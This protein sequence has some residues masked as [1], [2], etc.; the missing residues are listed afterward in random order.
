MK[1]FAITTSLILTAL[2]S[3]ELAYATAVVWPPAPAPARVEYVRQ[4]PLADLKPQTSFL[5]SIGRF[6][7][8]GTDD[9]ILG[10]PFNL[11]VTADR[12]YLTC[13]DHP[14]LVVIDPAENK[15]LRRD[16]EDHPMVSPIGLAQ[17]GADIYVADSGN[18][19]VYRWNGDDLEPWV[20]TGLVRPTGLIA[21]PKEQRIVVID[22]GD[23]QLKVFDSAGILLETVSQRGEHIGELNFPTF[24]ARLGDDLLVND[25]LNYQI[26]RFD[27]TGTLLTTFGAEGD[28]PGTFARPKGLAVDADANIWVVDALF[29]NI[30]VFNEQGQLLLVIGG[31]GQA[32]GE[33]WSPVGISVYRD[34]IYIADTFNHRIQVLRYLGGEF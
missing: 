6:L 9:E 33:F 17:L 22:T 34:E 8:G 27:S 7:G 14:A 32:E 4:I 13:Q 15:Y 31:P 5:G 2:L 19:T 18:G 28:G 29:D 16:C 20:T 23:H 11:I 24:G 26:K 10:L 12:I 25:T 21:L 1:R 3:V 30:Q